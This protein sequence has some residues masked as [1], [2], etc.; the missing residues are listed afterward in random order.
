MVI[1]QFFML[2]YQR[3]TNK[4]GDWMGLQWGCIADTTDTVHNDT[5]QYDS[6]SMSLN[7]GYLRYLP[8]FAN[9]SEVRSLK[10]ME[11]DM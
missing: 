2:N 9:Q 10:L 1:F 8:E 11:L 7:M 6:D 5:W 4:H 3:V